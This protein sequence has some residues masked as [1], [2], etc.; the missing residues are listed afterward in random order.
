METG[1]L[2]S[3]GPLQGWN[4]LGPLGPLSMIGRAYNNVLA[5]GAA[6][7]RR[8]AQIFYLDSYKAAVYS[9]QYGNTVTTGPPR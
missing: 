7:I 1:F 8:N 5:R 2:L 6:A 4:M 9:P 3:N